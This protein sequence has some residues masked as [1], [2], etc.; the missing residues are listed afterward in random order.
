MCKYRRRYDDAVH[1]GQEGSGKEQ[2]EA[3]SS[4]SLPFGIKIDG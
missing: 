4:K 2:R 3:P 1:G